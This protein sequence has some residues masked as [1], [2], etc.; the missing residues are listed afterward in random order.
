MVATDDPAAVQ[1]DEALLSALDQPPGVDDAE[2]AR[3]LV[4]WRREMDTEPVGRLVDV[5]T[6]VATIGA[7]R[8][9]R[10]IVFIALVVVAVLAVLLSVVGLIHLAVTR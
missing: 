10:E 4:A 9:R 3:V 1:A 7:A 6:A 5:D 8:R 2:L